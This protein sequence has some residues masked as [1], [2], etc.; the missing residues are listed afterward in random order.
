VL[1][2][3]LGG[4]KIPAESPIRYGSLQGTPH[5]S[6]KR[7]GDHL[8]TFTEQLIG[9]GH[10]PLKCLAILVGRP[11]DFTLAELCTPKAVHRACQGSEVIR[12]ARRHCVERPYHWARAA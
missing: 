1:L 4:L 9:P 10:Q 7:W 3:E 12:V 8:V 5:A 6:L 2:T 11:R